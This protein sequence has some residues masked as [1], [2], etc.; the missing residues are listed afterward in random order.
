MP[1]QFDTGNTTDKIAK[2]RNLENSVVIRGIATPSVGASCS[3]AQ[4]LSVPIH[5]RGSRDGRFVRVHHRLRFHVSDSGAA[6]KGNTT[7]ASSPTARTR[8]G[9]GDVTFSIRCCD[10]KNAPD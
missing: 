5:G 10:Q 7:R 9:S 2:H 6:A 8:T 1:R 4:V 3:A